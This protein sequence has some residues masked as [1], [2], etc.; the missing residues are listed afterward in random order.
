LGYAWKFA[1][2]LYPL[3]LELTLKSKMKELKKEKENQIFWPRR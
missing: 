2:G 3:T 1:D